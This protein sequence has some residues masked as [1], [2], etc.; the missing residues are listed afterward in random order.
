MKQKKNNNKKL[1]FAKKKWSCFKLVQRGVPW[2]NV[3]PLSP[4]TITNFQSPTHQLI[5]ILYNNFNNILIKT[6]RKHRFKKKNTHTEKAFYY[7][8]KDEYIFVDIY[9]I[10][11]ENNNILGGNENIEEVRGN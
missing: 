10:Y 2:E 7:S 5:H 4:S 3:G 8:D 11:G 6:H 9:Y 1:G